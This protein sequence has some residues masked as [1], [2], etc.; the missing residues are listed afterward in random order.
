MKKVRPHPKP[1]DTIRLGHLEAA[2]WSSNRGDLRF[3]LNRVVERYGKRNVYRSFDPQDIRE[4]MTVLA[5]VAMWYVHDDTLPR[6]VRDELK[7]I[8]EAVDAVHEVMETTP[9]LMNGK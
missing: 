5:H 3:T 9:A 6:R 8:A 4:L 1:F 7:L 2:F